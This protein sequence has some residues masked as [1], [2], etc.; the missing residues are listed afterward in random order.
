MSTSL[1]SSTNTYSDA[2]IAA[3]LR[4]LLAIAWADGQFDAQEQALITELTQTELSPTIDLGDITQGEAISPQEL[5][6]ALNDADATIAENFMR[7]AVMVAIADGIYSSSE[8]EVLHQ[9]CDA[10]GV[11]PTIL[12]P[13][14]SLRSTLADPTMTVVQPDSPL[15]QFHHPE[16]NF[17]MLNP[18]RNWLD[19]LEV[20]DPRLAKFLCKLIPAQCPFERDV[21]LFKRKV[22]H[23]P[24]MCQINPLYEQL[25]GLR[26][27]ALSYLA[28][29]CQE[30][31][32]KYC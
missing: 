21:V 10:L 15:S 24:P 31:V 8:D 12:T 13:L 28:D 23:I 2:Q 32:S 3:W 4:G 9:F 7:T 25:V 30:D 11:Q 17:V 16:P 20:K 5:A 22:V 18:V 1:S 27:R 19:H 6:A 29:E 14:E 26:F